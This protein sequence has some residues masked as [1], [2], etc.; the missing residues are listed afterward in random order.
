MAEENRVNPQNTETN[1]RPEQTVDRKISQSPTEDE[2]RDRIALAAYYNAERRGFQ[3]DRELDDWLEAE[4]QVGGSL[5]E[6]QIP[7]FQ[8]LAESDLV[9]NSG[10][11]RDHEIITPDAV[12]QWG[13]ELGV[14]VATLRVAI[15][16]VGA[17][18]D[19]VKDF[20]RGNA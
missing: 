15:K 12:K 13:K 19:D 6:D 2:R 9:I 7:I 3:G 20:L 10:D 16:R 11:P 14:P 8:A 5:Q 1:L 17:R 18:V 4:R